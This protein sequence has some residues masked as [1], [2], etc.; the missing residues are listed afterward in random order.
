MSSV[1]QSNPPLS[2]KFVNT[3]FKK[4]AWPI[5]RLQN[6]RRQTNFNR[7]VTSRWVDSRFI[8]TIHNPVLPGSSSRSF[9]SRTMPPST[10]LLRGTT[11]QRVTCTHL[12]A[13]CSPSLTVSDDELPLP[14]TCGCPTGFDKCD[15]TGVTIEVKARKCVSHCTIA[16]NYS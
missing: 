14:E 7:W 1:R 6:C 3:G 4:P 12:T 11:W 9:M 16:M 8:H 13:P 15:S 10:G 2:S 5:A